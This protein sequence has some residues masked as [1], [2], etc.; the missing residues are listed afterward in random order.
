[1]LTT[2]WLRTM[3]NALNSRQMNEQPCDYAANYLRSLV[4]WMN[5]RR[6]YDNDGKTVE[7]IM[8]EFNEYRNT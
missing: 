1:M 5:T 6:E 8:N 4:Y 3:K 2:Q 7:Q